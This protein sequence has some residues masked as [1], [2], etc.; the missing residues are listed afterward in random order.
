MRT[1]HGAKTG[2]AVSAVLVAAALSLSL[3]AC[4]DG[5]DK[6]GDG[7]GKVAATAVPPGSSG[8]GDRPADDPD[9]GLEAS[10]ESRTLATVKGGNG[11]EFTITGAAREEGGFLTVSG[12]LTNSGDK[13]ALPPLQW[14]G[15]ETQVMRRGPSLGG[16]TLL[17]K[18]DKKRYY[19]LRDTDGY[20]LTTT[21]LSSFTAGQSVDFF[22]QFPAPPE[23]TTSVELQIPLMPSATIEIS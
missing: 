13:R 18:K 12:V 21:G 1:R 15:Q 7:K 5:G 20:P 9:G 16:I 2:R 14:S 19:V 11:F 3:T 17:D 22:A 23:S 10:D 6:G 8:G 4:G